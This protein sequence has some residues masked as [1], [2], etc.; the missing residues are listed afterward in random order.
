MASIQYGTSSSSSAPSSSTSQAQRPLPFDMESQMMSYGTY[1]TYNAVNVQEFEQLD[2]FGNPVPIDVDFQQRPTPGTECCAFLFSIV[3][4]GYTYFGVTY[5]ITD[6][7]VCPGFSPLWYAVL[8]MIVNNC[9]LSCIPVST[10]PL[11][12]YIVFSVV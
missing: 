7:N 5:L 10:K 11:W 9:L 2:D 6:E 1:G 4:F 8:W 12:P 3:S